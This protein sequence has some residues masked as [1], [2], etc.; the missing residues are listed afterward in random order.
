MEDVGEEFSQYDFETIQ[1]ATN[2]FDIENELGKGGFG[3]V[4]KVKKL[5]AG[6]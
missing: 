6:S 4:Y 5:R 3:L 2:N 1:K